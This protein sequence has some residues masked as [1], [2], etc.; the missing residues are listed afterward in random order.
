MAASS[1]S[2]LRPSLLRAPLRASMFPALARG[3]ISPQYCNLNQSPEALGTF[4]RSLWNLPSPKWRPFI[5]P[6]PLLSPTLP[7][8]PCPLVLLSSFEVIYKILFTNIV[9]DIWNLSM[10]EFPLF[11]FSIFQYAILEFSR[12]TFIDLSSQN[13]HKYIRIYTNISHMREADLKLTRS[14]ASQR[15]SDQP[16]AQAHLVDDGLLVLPHGGFHTTGAF[17]RYQSEGRY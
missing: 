4:Y 7:Q 10:L 2:S 3:D 5:A 17:V 8:S 11:P 6:F 16:W 9:S 14:R 1:R 13:L 12:A 15:S